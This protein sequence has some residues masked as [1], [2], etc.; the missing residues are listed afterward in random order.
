MLR[1]KLGWQARLRLDPRRS[2]AQIGSV[3]AASVDRVRAPGTTGSRPSADGH[4]SL[5]R[6]GNQNAG[7]A[8]GGAPAGCF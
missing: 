6:P 4:E 8:R 2:R 3:G 1:G 5:I 7:L